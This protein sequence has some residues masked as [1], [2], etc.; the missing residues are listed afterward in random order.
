MLIETSNSVTLG[1]RSY[2]SLKTTATVT[3]EPLGI[4]RAF[5]EDLGSLY[6]SNLSVVD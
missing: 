2:W 6:A 1:A 4:G 3:E 5:S